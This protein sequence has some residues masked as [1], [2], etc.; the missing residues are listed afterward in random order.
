MQQI[1]QHPYDVMARIRTAYDSLTKSQ[2]KVAE[3]LL[4]HGVEV[5]YLSA[6]RIAEMLDVNRSTV[7]RTAQAIGYNGFPEMQ[8]ALQ[9]QLLSGI[10]SAE[11]YQFG[12]RQLIEDITE[13][14]QDQQAEPGEPNGRVESSVIKPANPTDMG[15]V[16]HHVIRTEMRNIEQLI[17]AV[18]TTD[19][20]RA[21]QMLGSARH[22]F[23][24]G[25][26]ASLPLALNFG[27]P[28]R[29]IHKQCSVLTEGLTSL[30]DQLEDMTDQDV[31]FAI[32]YSRYAS[33]TLA[34]M[35][36]ARGLGAKVIALTD[37]PLSPAAKRAD[38]AFIIPYKVWL[39]ANSAA[40][41]VLLNA[42]FTA[43]FLRRSEVIPE[44]LDHLDQIYAAFRTFEKE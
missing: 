36:Y 15:S 35:D 39:Y 20:A 31:L 21:T 3:F 27:H 41:F 16:L 4:T 26:R 17:H 9:A 1:E 37:S 23:V 29:F 30:A 28:M 14:S 11:R 22:I 13:Q 32:S 42:L 43:M 12:S 24:I 18:P 34:C 2:Q 33:N 19:F 44:R 6:A 5:V 38:V 40:P 7:I 25:L 10:G 8:A